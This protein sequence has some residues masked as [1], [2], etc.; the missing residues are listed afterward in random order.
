MIKILQGSAVTQTVLGGLYILQLYISRSVYIPKIIM[1]VGRHSKSCYCNNNQAS[2]L[3][4]HLCWQKAVS[5][6]TYEEQIC[7]CW[8]QSL[9]THQQHVLQPQY[10]AVWQPQRQVCRSNRAPQW[11]HRQSPAQV[12]CS[13]VLEHVHDS[14]YLYYHTHTH[15]LFTAQSPIC[16]S[17][18]I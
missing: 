6:I 3:A 14:S 4:H 13:S 18:L 1:K 8:S 9:G 7:R 11:R 10:T 16:P 12:C 2:F 15:F 17:Y 5:N